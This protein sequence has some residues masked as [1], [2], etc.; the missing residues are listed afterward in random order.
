MAH[1]T[2]E[3]T[4]GFTDMELAELRKAQE[5]LESENFAEPENIADLLNNEFQ[6]GM[7]AAALYTKVRDGAGVNS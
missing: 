3:N 1:W 4:D 2:H 5:M 6:P 7:D